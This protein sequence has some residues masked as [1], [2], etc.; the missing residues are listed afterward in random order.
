[1]KLSCET[2]FVSR[3]ILL[4]FVSLELDG[5][6][7]ELSALRVQALVMIDGFER[8]DIIVGRFNHSTL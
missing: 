3:F 8:F 6:D 7:S 2:L 5:F 4:I 1:M